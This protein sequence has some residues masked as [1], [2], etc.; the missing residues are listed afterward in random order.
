MT[1]LLTAESQAEIKKLLASRSYYVGV[2]GQM[3]FSAADDV[4]SLVL[5]SI[6]G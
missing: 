5:S 4:I 6:T 3:N 2:N 1:A